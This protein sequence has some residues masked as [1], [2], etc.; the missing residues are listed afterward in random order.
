MVD[1]SFFKDAKKNAYKREVQ[2]VANGELLSMML[3]DTIE[4]KIGLRVLV[5]PEPDQ[6]PTIYRTL[7]LSLIPGQLPTVFK[8]LVGDG[9]K[10]L[11][12]AVAGLAAVAVVSA[13]AV[14]TTTDYSEC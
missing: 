5:R 8:S 2:G 13:V 9:C 10:R 12:V 4:V 6:P 3:S 1:F 7:G 11:M 14:V